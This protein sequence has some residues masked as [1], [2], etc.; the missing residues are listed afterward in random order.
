VLSHDERRLMQHFVLDP[1]RVK[2]CRA[3]VGTASWCSLFGNIFGDPTA[4]L[5]Q[6]PCYTARGLKFSK[7]RSELAKIRDEIAEMKR[8]T[9]VR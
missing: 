8:T 3:S 2:L 9:S 7:R 6:M 1:K 5:P 4:V